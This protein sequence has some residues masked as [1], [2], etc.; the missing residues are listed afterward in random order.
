MIGDYKK[1]TGWR[2][3][4]T[5][6]D[7]WPLKN[8]SCCFAWLL[9]IH[10]YQRFYDITWRVFLRFLESVS[11]KVNNLN[12]IFIFFNGRHIFLK[13]LYVNFLSLGL[14]W[15]SEGT[16][17]MQPTKKKK[18]SI[19]IRKYAKYSQW[20]NIFFFFGLTHKFGFVFECLINLWL[21]PWKLSMW[22]NLATS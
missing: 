11:K 2:H 4:R 8:E 15:I 21:F 7:L 3:R 1:T 17:S 13:M 20:Q 14:W 9:H 19:S 6:T 18:S 16:M 10:L 22:F 5:Y 12:F